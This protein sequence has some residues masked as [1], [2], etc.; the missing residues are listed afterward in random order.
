MMTN[1]TIIMSEELFGP[2]RTPAP[3]MVTFANAPWFLFP[4][5]VIWRMRKEHPF[6]GA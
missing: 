4:I 2:H 5:L 3:G 1:V 6:G